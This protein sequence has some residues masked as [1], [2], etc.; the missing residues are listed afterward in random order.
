MIT[1]IGHYLTVLV[2]TMILGVPTPHS[3]VSP[4][5]PSE[6]VCNEAKQTAEFEIQQVDGAVSIAWCTE[7][8]PQP[9]RQNASEPRVGTT[10]GPSGNLN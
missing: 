1:E 3:V 4:V 5:L 2:V 7:V 6:S 8:G 9:A 10:N